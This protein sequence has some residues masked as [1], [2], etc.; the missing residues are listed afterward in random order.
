MRKMIV[1]AEVSMDGVDAGAVA[2]GCPTK[3]SSETGRRAM[4]I[5]SGVREKYDPRSE[6]EVTPARAQDLCTSPGDWPNYDEKLLRGRDRQAVQWDQ[7]YVV[8]ARRGRYGA[9]RASARLRD[10]ADAKRVKQD[11]P[12]L[13]DEETELVHVLPR[14]NS[15]TL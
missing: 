10:I 13:V 15:S 3:G 9:G 2:V 12:N 11:G 1:G 5:R 7:K 14:A 8:R 4:L 6:E